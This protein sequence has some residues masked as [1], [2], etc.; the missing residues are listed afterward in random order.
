MKDKKQGAA[1]NKTKS[2]MIQTTRKV[3]M[4]GH[5]C[6]GSGVSGCSGGNGG[7]GG[8]V[9]SEGSD[10]GC[11]NSVMKVKQES[12]TKIKKHINQPQY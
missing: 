9:G 5:R 3:C 11:D 10:D 6:G 2:T 1:K 12:V 7:N 4:R 8:S